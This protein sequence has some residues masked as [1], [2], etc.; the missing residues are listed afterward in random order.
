MSEAV[1]SLTDTGAAG[2][3]VPNVHAWGD[4]RAPLPYLP[5]FFTRTT[6]CRILGSAQTS[7][8]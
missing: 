7:V 2:V 6:T 5:A 3:L 4:R 8:R 1:L